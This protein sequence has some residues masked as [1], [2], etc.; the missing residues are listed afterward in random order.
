MSNKESRRNFIKSAGAAG[1]GIIAGRMTSCSPDAETNYSQ[2]DI[3]MARGGGNTGI[4]EMK[5][6]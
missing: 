1:T 2:V 3:E 5:K 6:I 4:K